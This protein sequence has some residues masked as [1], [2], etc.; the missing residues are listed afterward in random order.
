VRRRGGGIAREE[1][2][3]LCRIVHRMSERPLLVFDGDDTLWLVEVLYDEARS[4]AGRIVAEAGLDARRWDSCQRVRD[5]QN[6][7][8]LGLS[9]ERFPTSC[10]EAYAEVVR[11]S[12]A[13]V[14][15]F[16]QERIAAAAREVFDRRAELADGAE[17]TVALLAASYGLA[18]L[19]QGD[20]TV[21]EKRVADSGLAGYFDV[22]SIVDRKTTGSFRQVLHAFGVAPSRSWSIGN[23]LSSDINPA[24]RCGMSAIWIDAHVWD[25]ERREQRAEPGRLLTAT[26]LAEV[27]ELL[28]A[29]VPC[30]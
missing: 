26:N 21:Q 10:V 8:T 7:H 9:R 24:L 18:L 14:D 11:Q 1:L 13:R 22:I 23:S 19:T 6:A 29:L 4:R 5:V 28:A 2:S 16:V 3:H 25:Y 15:P 20:R 17:Q 12:G 30:R 27:P